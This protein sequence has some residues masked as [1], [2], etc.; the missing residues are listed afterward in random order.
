M[1]IFEKILCP[2][3]FSE[4]SVKALQWTQFL[5]N[6]FQSEVLILHVMAPFPLGTVTDVGMDYDRYYATVNANLDEFL[7]PLNIKYEK[8]ISSGYPAG[9]IVALA[10]GLHASLIVTGTRGMQGAVHKFLGS[11]TEAVVRTASVPVFTI[12]PHCELPKEQDTH[13]V[14]IPLASLFRMPRRSIRLRKLIRE[15][16]SVPT[17]MHVVDFHDQMFNA[18]F[19][20][21]PF[22]VASHETADKAEQLAR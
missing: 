6:R 15:L 14:L 19:D 12:S 21:N 2:V 20:A 18:S 4:N 10:S 8:M 17:F 1:R 3:D 13:E 9:K 7:A 11:T 5:A 16:K 22:L